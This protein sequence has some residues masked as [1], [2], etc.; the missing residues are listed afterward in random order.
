MANYEESLETTCQLLRRHVDDA[1]TINPTDHIQKDLGLDSLSVMELVA[2][3]E[4][5]F[6]VSVPSEMY[7]G[8][9]TVADVAR[10]V[11]KLTLSP[12]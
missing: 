7:G 1:T 8:I 10:A 4:A 2:D 6:G 5:K 3:L 12:T 9:E 11:S